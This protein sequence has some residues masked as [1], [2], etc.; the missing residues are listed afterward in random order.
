MT[1]PNVHER[2]FGGDPQYLGSFDFEVEENI[3]LD[4]SGVEKFDIDAAAV[5]LIY[6]LNIEPASG[7]PYQFKIFD[8]GTYDDEDRCF[9]TGSVSGDYDSVEEDVGL[10]V[11]PDKDKGSHIHCKMVGTPGDSFDMTFNLVRM[12]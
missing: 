2:V 3:V 9:D 6:R 4:G 10:I 5:N 7:N 11:C 8:R 1:T 12:K